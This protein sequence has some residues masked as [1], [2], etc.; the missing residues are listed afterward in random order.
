[1]K[2]FDIV[3]FDG[4]KRREDNGVMANSPQELAAL[5]AMTDEKIIEILREYEDDDC[6]NYGKFDPNEILQKMNTP[7]A[8][9]TM[10]PGSGMMRVSDDIQKMIDSTVSGGTMDNTTADVV[11]ITPS[12]V[13]PDVP[14]GT[15]PS[16][17]GTA[18]GLIRTNPSVKPS[19]PQDTVYFKVGDV[20]CKMEN[21]TVYQKKWTPASESDMRKIRIVFDKT[22]KDVPMA[23]KHIEILKWEVANEDPEPDPI[24]EDDPETENAEN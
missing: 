14:R 17:P 11:K 24:Q 3:V 22:G 9:G 10:A 15:I 4:V 19:A 16:I 5:Y 12:A 23:G 21:G 18:T 1:M 20:E 6:K 2:K 13:P 7:M 8:K